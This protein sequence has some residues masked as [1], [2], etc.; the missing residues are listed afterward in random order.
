M[1]NALSKE[2]TTTT[3]KGITIKMDGNLSITGISIDDTAKKNLEENLK[4]ATNT[5]IK[6]TQKLMARKMQ[7]MGGLSN[8]NL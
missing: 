2:S 5:A 3:K 8:F 7:E 4:E 1:Q 6:D